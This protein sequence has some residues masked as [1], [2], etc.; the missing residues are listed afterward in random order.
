MPFTSYLMQRSFP[1]DSRIAGDVACA[2]CGYNLRG[3]LAAGKCPECGRP[4]GES[5]WPLTRPDKVAGSVRRIG[6]SFLGVGAA[7]A[8]PVVVT[9]WC[10]GWLALGAL[11]ITTAVRT[12]EVAELRFRADTDK[13]PVVGD[14]VRLLWLAS[15]A[16]AVILLVWS[17]LLVSSGLGENFLGP[18]AVLTGVLGVVWL[19]AAFAVVGLAG[20]MG[21]A[22]AAMLGRPKVLRLMS[23]QVAF[24]VA[25]PAV[26]LGFGVLGMAVTLVINGVAG[27]VTASFGV[28][29]LIT[30]WVV[31]VVLTLASTAQLATA[32]ERTRDPREEMLDQ[33]FGVGG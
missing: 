13:L 30:M 3:S 2:G 29:G 19:L 23:T 12:V 7:V 18:L 15:M 11:I 4:A 14:R 21:S 10:L 8:V 31:A 17:L 24:T 26:A 25:G 32:V 5:L 9:G 1:A 16:E 33:G 6:N 20:W 22:M 28:V 27:A